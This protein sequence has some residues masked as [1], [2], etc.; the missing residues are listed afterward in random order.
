MTQRAGILS[1][2]FVA[3]T[4]WNFWVVARWGEGQCMFLGEESEP[5]IQ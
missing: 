5:N 3:M 2:V 1:F 4:T